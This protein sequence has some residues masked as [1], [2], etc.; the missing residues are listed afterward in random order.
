M[1]VEFSE[2]FNQELVELKAFISRDSEFYAENF[3]LSL[4]ASL[5]KLERF[6]AAGRKVPGIKDPLVRE[7]VYRDY[8]IIYRL[9]TE[10]IIV[11]FLFHGK[12]DPQEL[13]QFLETPIM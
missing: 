3:I 12:R 8:R 9:E 1:K 11:L 6:P 10:R 13:I 4:R 5:Q 7:I 2:Y